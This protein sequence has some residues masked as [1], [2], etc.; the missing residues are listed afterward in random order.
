MRRS[1]PPP[2]ASSGGRGEFCLGRQAGAP[3]SPGGPARAR[4]QRSTRLW[5]GRRPPLAS[6]QYATKK[7][8]VEDVNDLDRDLNISKLKQ[9]EFQ[10]SMRAY[11]MHM[12]REYMEYEATGIPRRSATPPQPGQERRPTTQSSASHENE[13]LH[14]HN[15]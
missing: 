11:R 6:T 3:I 12:M 14:V 7:V 10:K 5:L 2:L 1:P 13:M 9:A 15:W 8:K 4:W